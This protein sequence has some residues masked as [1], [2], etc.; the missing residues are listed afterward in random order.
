MMPP[1]KYQTVFDELRHRHLFCDAVLKVEGE[2]FPVHK[3]ILCRSSPYFRAIF[4]CR[5]TRDDRD[6]PLDGISP[7]IMSLVLDWIYTKSIT[8]NSKNM[9]EVLLAADMLLLEKLVDVC[10]QFMKDHMSPENCIGI[11]KFADVVVSAKMRDLA[12]RFILR[13]FEEVVMRDEFQQ[14]SAQELSTFIENDEIN[15]RNETVVFDAVLH[16]TKYDLKRR[17]AEFSHLLSKLDPEF[18]KNNVLNHALVD[19][20]VRTSAGVNAVDGIF[21]AVNKDSHNLL[22]YPRLPGAILLAIGG[23]R[24]TKPTNGIEAYDIKTNSWVNVSKNREK[25]WGYHGTVFFNGSIYCVGG[26]DQIKH[27]NN[28]RRL[29]LSTFVWHEMPPMYYRRNYV[30]VALLNGRIYA[31][32]GQDGQRGQR[33]LMTAE[34]YD[35]Q[36]N[37]W[38]LIAPMCQQRSGASCAALNGK[39]Y[40][41]GGFTG[42]E[43]LQ[44]AECYCPKTNRWTLIAPMTARRTGVAVVA[45]ANSIYAVG[46][47]DGN[48]CLRSVE[49]YSPC[50]DSWRQVAPMTI[51]RT[52]F[53]MEVLDDRIFAVGGCTGQSTTCKVES[54]N[55]LLDAWTEVCDMD[56]LRSGLSC[57]VISGLDNM[58]DFIIPRHILAMICSALFE[59]DGSEESEET[60]ESEES[61]E[62]EE[63]DE[64]FTDE[65]DE[66]VDESRLLNS[67]NN[68]SR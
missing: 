43:N 38:S 13:H 11:W 32:G 62:S 1:E 37:Q 44:T 6:F 31:M 39:I 14:L 3:V 20:L 53:G 19:E 50:T 68:A 12:Q 4:E 49:V 42:A 2:E 54:Y 51:P 57:C 56:S 64:E 36:T 24:G 41:C 18:V 55:P 22:Y 33:G 26:Y 29:D 8:L 7:K 30:S 67:R 45:H 60:D 52:Y 21:K 25:P 40:I 28:V 65:E 23:W 58:A 5:G 47:F 16:W 66:S 27:L 35:P 63:L 46:G 10:F 15:V 61:N 9:Q 59:S 17:K 34:V 48:I